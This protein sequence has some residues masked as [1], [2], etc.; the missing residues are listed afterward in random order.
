MAQ[1]LIEESVW[2]YHRWFMQFLLHFTNLN[3]K[4]IY[5]VL[6]TKYVTC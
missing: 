3:V 6:K 1:N 4:S 5:N 2:F